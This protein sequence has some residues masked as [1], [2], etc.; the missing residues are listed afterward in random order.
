MLPLI[1][2]V[3]HSGMYDYTSKYTAGATDYLVPAPISPE[4][5]QEM[6][7]RPGVGE[8][9]GCCGVAR[10]LYDGCGR[11][12]LYF[13]IEHGTGDDDDQSGTESGASG[14]DRFHRAV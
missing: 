5:T 14:R 12:A 6:Q 4:L 11:Q 10:R 8:L 3:L 1:Q 2:I 13:G 7:E 9:M